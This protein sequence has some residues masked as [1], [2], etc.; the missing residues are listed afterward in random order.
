MY[1]WGYG[2][3]S[4]A[5]ITASLDRWVDDALGM[6]MVTLLGPVTTKSLVNLI[7]MISV[8]KVKW[9]SLNL[10]YSFS[11]RPPTY[12]KSI[13]RLLSAWLIRAVKV[14]AYSHPSLSHKSIKGSSL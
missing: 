4:S 14:N 3:H 5:T 10:T 6:G 11:L 2:D 7:T 12:R 1:D 9:I 13:S 8:S